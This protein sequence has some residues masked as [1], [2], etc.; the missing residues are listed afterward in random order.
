VIALAVLLLL[1][2]APCAGAI[3]M[4]PQ[5]WVGDTI[6]LTGTTNLA[7][8]DQV[9][10]EVISASFA[11][12]QKGED[13]TFSGATGIVTVEHGTWSYSFSTAGFRQDQYLVTAEAIGIGVIDRGS[14]RL[15][16]RP[17]GTTVGTTVSTAVS[18]PST[19]TVPVTGSPTATP[20]AGSPSGLL[21]LPILIIPL[22][23]RRT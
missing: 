3:R 15:M 5:Y 16:E 1:L 6:T 21:V 7:T 20:K 2:P 10:V 13:T 22:L 17:A 23:R 11:P 14:F 4:Q 18:P 8:G 12:A 9:G 19:A